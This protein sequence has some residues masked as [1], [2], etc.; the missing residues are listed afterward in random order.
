MI[1]RKIGSTAL[2]LVSRSVL[3]TS[4]IKK[5]KISIGTAMAVPIVIKRERDGFFWRRA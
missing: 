4:R 2:L 1:N 3:A 5:E